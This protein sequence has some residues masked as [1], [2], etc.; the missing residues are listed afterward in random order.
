MFSLCLGFLEF[1]SLDPLS[2]CDNL[3][4]KT[5][6]GIAAIQAALTGVVGGRF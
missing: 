6:V 2:P 4:S 5:V 3:I 1:C